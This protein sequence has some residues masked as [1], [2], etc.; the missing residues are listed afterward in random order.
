VLR[1]ADP[2]RGQ[3]R[4]MR[5]AEGG[6]QAPLQAFVLAGDIRAR[7]WVLPLW[8]DAQ[9]ARALGTRLL[10]ASPQPP[11][12][13]QPRGAQVCSCFDVGEA[14]IR[15]TLATLQGSADARLVQLQQRLHCGTNCGSCK[16]ALRVLVGQSLEAA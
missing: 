13:F 8:R 4:A 16:P 2:K 7:D 10:A 14:Q 1:Y 5:L 11:A 15:S 3:H 12:A 6:D 9:P